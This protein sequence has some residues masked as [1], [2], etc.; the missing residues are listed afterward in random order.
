MILRYY[1]TWEKLAGKYT[2]KDITLYRF[3][4]AVFAV[5]AYI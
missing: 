2:I 3:L 5:R 1:Y 4:W